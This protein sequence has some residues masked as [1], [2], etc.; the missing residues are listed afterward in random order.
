[1]ELIAKA[2]LPVCGLMK[3]VQLSNRPGHF[4]I[5]DNDSYQSPNA[6]SQ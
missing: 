6:A 2:S 1:M 4:S 3:N 5:F